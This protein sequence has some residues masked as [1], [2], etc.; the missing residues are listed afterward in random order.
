M[1][2]PDYKDYLDTNDYQ[3]GL[4]LAVSGGIFTTI[5]LID[6]LAIQLEAQ[7]AFLGGKLGDD[8]QYIIQDTPVIQIPILVKG[9][10]RAGNLIITPLAGPAV[11]FKMGEWK[12]VVRTSSGTEISSDTFPDE[13][14]ASFIIGAVAGAGL[15]FSTR[16]GTLS[17]EARYLIG[18]TQIFAESASPY[19]NVRQDAVLVLIG[20]GFPIIK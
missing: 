3:T 17:V 11:M 20:F 8:T 2:G 4:T 7:Y 6:P 10:I 18:L 16:I 1:T 14:I 13:D 9:R 5:G 12:T 15:E 19:S